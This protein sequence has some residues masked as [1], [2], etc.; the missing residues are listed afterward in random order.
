MAAG[1]QAGYGLGETVGGLISDKP[2]SPEQTRLGTA[3]GVMGLSSLADYA[4]GQRQYGTPQVSAA[5]KDPQRPGVSP[6][7]TYVMPDKAAPVGVPDDD[8][9]WKWGPP[10]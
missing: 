1:A 3:A 4:R 9:K 5:G 2:G 7:S 10:E 8:R 6:V